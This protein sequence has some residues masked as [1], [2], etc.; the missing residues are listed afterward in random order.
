MKLRVLAV[1]AVATALCA[2]AGS[3]LAGARGPHPAGGPAAGPRHV[4]VLVLTMFSGETRPWL[5]HLKLPVTVTVPGGYGPLHCDSGG[6][7]V[8]TI[9]QGKSNAGPSVTAILADRMLSFRGA[10]FMT[11]GIAGTPPRWARSALPPGHAT[12]PT[13]IRASPDSPHGPATSLRVRAAQSGQLRRGLPPERGP[14]ADGIPGD[15]ARPAG[16]LRQADRSRARYPG[17]AAASRSWRYATP[18]PGM[19][20]GQARRCRTRR[21]TSCPSTPA[22]T[23]CTAPPN[24]RTP[25][26]PRRSAGSV[27][28]AVTST[29]VRPATSISPT[30]VKPSR[31]CWRPFR[32]RHRGRERLPRRRRD[33][34]LP[35]DP[36][37]PARPVIVTPGPPR[38]AGGSHRP[39]LDQPRDRAARAIR[40]SESGRS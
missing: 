33:G 10:Y 38:V 3:A 14:G 32:L 35:H 20:T 37:R 23:A 26:S 7:C 11:A 17:Q 40:P 5:A 18:W 31:S 12:S 8:T 2:G 39:R 21:T 1:A 4:R 6:L 27:T 28:S 36:R 34:P 22:G 29:C 25:R 9:G 13:G 30:P 24:R 15:P 19:T 16:R